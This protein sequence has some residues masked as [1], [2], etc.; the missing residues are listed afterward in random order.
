MRLE[1][2]HRAWIVGAALFLAAAAL[3]ANVC[4]VAESIGASVGE[5]IRGLVLL[6]VSLHELCDEG[7]PRLIGMPI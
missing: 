6:H 3:R 5:A 4:V 1:P 7:I 2:S